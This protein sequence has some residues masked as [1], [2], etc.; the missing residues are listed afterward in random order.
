MSWSDNTPLCWVDKVHVVMVVTISS[1]FQWPT[2]T[3]LELLGD[4]PPIPVIC[5]PTQWRC[6]ICC[7][8]FKHIES[9]GHT[10]CNCCQ[11]LP[12]TSPFHNSTVFINDFAL[13]KVK[14]CVWLHAWCLNEWLELVTWMSRCPFYS[15]YSFYWFFSEDRIAKTV[16]N[17][18]ELLVV[19]PFNFVWGTLIVIIM[20]GCWAIFKG[21]LEIDFLS[22]RI[23][24]SG[25][26]PPS[27]IVFKESVV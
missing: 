21:I 7:I 3:V 10:K 4:L 19:T 27:V 13:F 8:H 11:S 1:L 14:G 9:W 16:C 6:T 2:A 12:E 24:S 20:T 15:E 22:L 17:V 26:L 5:H 18:W 25:G 23:P